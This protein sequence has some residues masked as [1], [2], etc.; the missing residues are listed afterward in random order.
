MERQQKKKKDGNIKEKIC[1]VNKIGNIQ[2]RL[3]VRV[4]KI[5]KITKKKRDSAQK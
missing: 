2:F 4:R 3:R 5:E 1:Y